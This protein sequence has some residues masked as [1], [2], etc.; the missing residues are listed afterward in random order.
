MT[1]QKD[2]NRKKIIT[3][4][5]GKFSRRPRVQDRA[6]LGYLSIYENTC[7]VAATLL[8][9]SRKDTGVTGA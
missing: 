1:T 3:H 4:F 6:L 7:K 8:S 5:G 2:Q 9:H